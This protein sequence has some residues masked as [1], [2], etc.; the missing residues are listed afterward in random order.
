[1][2]RKP[3]GESP[4]DKAARLRERRLA[5]LDRNIASQRTSAD[6]TGDLRAVYGLRGLGIGSGSAAGTPP[7]SRDDWMKQM[8]WNRIADRSGPTAA[9][10]VVGKPK[11]DPTIK[12]PRFTP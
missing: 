7:A 5:E 3:P 11:R 4:E 10:A 12:I 6:M 2:A 9:D 8:I 1:M